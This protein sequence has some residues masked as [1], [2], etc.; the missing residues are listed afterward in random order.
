M[1]GWCIVTLASARLKASVWFPPLKGTYQRGGTCKG[2]D[3]FGEFSES[4]KATMASVDEVR[5]MLIALMGAQR[6]GPSVGPATQTM[7]NVTA[8]AQELTLS[9]SEHEVPAMDRPP[10]QFVVV[11]QTDVMLQASVAQSTLPYDMDIG[12]EEAQNSPPPSIEEGRAEV[13]VQ[14]PTENELV[15]REE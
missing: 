12:V 1:L 8:T 5:R 3:R 6:R 2:C 9:D 10:P 4:L 15:G 14:P 7:A 11:P 13:A